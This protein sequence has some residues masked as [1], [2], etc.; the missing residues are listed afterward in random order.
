MNKKEGWTQKDIP[1]LS[2]K[3]AI[4]TGANSGIG[5]EAARHLS[6]K[7]A[8]IIM[9]CR[10]HEKGENAK[11]LILNENSNAKLDLMELDLSSL[12]SVRN[13]S[14][15]VPKKYDNVDIL[16]NNAGVSVPQF[17]RTKD[18]FELHFG[19]NYLGHFALTGLLLPLI[20]KVK[21]SRIVTMT[22]ANLRKIDFDDI[23]C[24]KRRA[25]ALTLYG[26]SKL[27]CLMFTLELNDRLKMNGY[28]TIS[29]AAQPGLSRTGLYNHSLL[30]KIFAL[31]ILRII[32]GSMSAEDGSRPVLYAATAPEAKGGSFYAP[33]GRAQAT[34][35]PKE[36]DLTKKTFFVMSELPTKEN[37]EHL[38]KVSE[39]MTKIKYL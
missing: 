27:A 20:V 7:G 2:N 5:F 26:R 35:F 34:G 1:D 25:S 31:G 23:N 17:S 9:G 13:F 32:F 3:I 28:S 38:W 29:L 21:D 10:N 24:E 19:V 15:G 11:Q 36:I 8:T 12:D 4:I 39:E 33:D 6:R 14:A 16:I 37:Q 30:A 18:G 22:S